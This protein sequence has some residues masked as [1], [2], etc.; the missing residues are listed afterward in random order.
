MK[1]LILFLVLILMLLSGGLTA[2]NLGEPACLVMPAPIPISPGST[3]ENTF[4]PPGTRISFTWLYTGDCLPDQFRVLVSRISTSPYELGFDD[5]AVLDEKITTAPPATIV[6]EDGSIAYSMGWDSGVTLPVGLYSWRVT[7]YS[8]WYSGERSEWADLIIFDLCDS[9]DDYSLA[10]RLIYPRYGQTVSR[11]D[12]G[13]YWLDDNTCILPGVFQ[14]QVSEFTYFPAEATIE[15][16]KFNGTYWQVTGLNYC[17]RYYWR[18]RTYFGFYSPG[19]VSETFYFDTASSDGRPC[20]PD[21]SEPSAPTPSSPPTAKTLD[22][23]NCRAGPSLDF[24][25]LSIL[26]AGNQYEI[27]ARNTPG[28]SW[29]VFDPSINNTCWVFADLVEVFG[30]DTGL[31]MIIDP[32]PPPLVMPTETAE[33]VD[34]SQYNTDQNACNANQACWWDSSVPP[35][36]TCKNK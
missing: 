6:Y 18:V 29:M 9:H 34:C 33:T 21:V 2:C 35:N 30:G 20:P 11:L 23:A 4:L 22:H 8:G 15:S 7:P 25:V 26:P 28:D 19:P 5:L 3:S 32:D 14:A 12:S 17:T 27:R 16:P 10:P 1:R 24:P 36:G 31:V 13:L